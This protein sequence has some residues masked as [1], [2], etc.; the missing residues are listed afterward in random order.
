MRASGGTRGTLL[1]LTHSAPLP[2]I[3]GHRIRSYNLLR[4]LV[5]RGWSVRLF[6][7]ETLAPDEDAH[8]ALEELCT[9]VVVHRFERRSVRRRLRIARN[10][11][12]RQ[13]FQLDYFRDAA[14]ERTLRPLLE[15]PF[16]LIV[17]AQLYMLGYVPSRL[18]PRVVFDS[19]NAEVRRLE[20]MGNGAPP[21]RR[22]AA[23]LQLGPVR[24]LEADAARSVARVLAVSAEEQAYF[25][26][27]SG[28]AAAL[29]PNG[30]DVDLL[31]PRASQPNAPEFLFMGSFDYSANVD[32]ARHLI[33]DVVPRVQRLASFTILGAGPPQAVLRDAERSR[34]PVRVTGFVKATAPYV[35]GSRGLVVPLRHGGGTRL[36]ILEALARGLPVV[37][38]TIGCEGL[39]LVDGHDVLVADEPAELARCIDRLAVDDDLCALLAENGRRTV[40]ERFAWSK[41]GADLDELLQETIAVRNDL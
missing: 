40:E 18:R 36:K 20:A 24:A 8:A 41:I 22:A 12:L 23:R 32:A 34:L 37:S 1:Y 30:V 11:V 3:S 9:D 31:L 39:G 28:R 26:R 6:A 13:P 27:I 35:D 4:Q 16:D 25:E 19:V 7:L 2:P 5:P 14:A 29:I 21:F 10:L 15:R 33:R 17:V 38:T